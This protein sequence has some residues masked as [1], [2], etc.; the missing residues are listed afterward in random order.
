MGWL[1]FG[2]TAS[3]IEALF[4]IL[5]EKF[6]IDVMEIFP[7]FKNNAEL[8]N[9]RL[10]S[11]INAQ[12]VTENISSYLN[13]IQNLQQTNRE[14]YLELFLSYALQS[15]SEFNFEVIFH[16]TLLESNNILKRDSWW[17][18]FI[19]N[20][21]T[22]NGKVKQIIE[23]SLSKENSYHLDSNSL[24]LSGIT[25]SWFLTSSNREL[26][27]T[28]TKAL[29]NLFTNNINIFLKVLKEFERVDDLYVLERLYAVGY[30]ITLRSDKL[31]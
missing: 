18:I 30:G 20:N 22:K 17:S 6:K 25:L 29:V 28:T 24:Y 23:W 4:T 26:R 12:I 19:H 31:D 9:L 11:F 8:M 21:Y 15:D 27:D 16:K 7:N 1:Y 14:Y 2:L 3:I 13:D 5:L 10:K